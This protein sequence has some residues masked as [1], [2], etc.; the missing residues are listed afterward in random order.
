MEKKEV[1]KMKRKESLT[2]TSVSIP[3]DFINWIKDNR[4]E[5]VSEFI[6]DAV[7][8]KMDRLIGHEGQLAE[9]DKRIMEKQIELEILNTERHSVEEAHSRWK[10]EKELEDLSSLIA[11]AIKKIN[12]TSWE[13]AAKDLESA[14]KNVSRESFDDLVQ[15][16]WT[17]HRI[18]HEGEI[19][20]DLSSY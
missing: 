13:D 3:V 8:E 15:A 11:K 4:R 16:I 12:Y 14:R 20:V 18:E 7:S 6:R 9:I 19:I 5:S 17:R 2:V 10:D 1:T